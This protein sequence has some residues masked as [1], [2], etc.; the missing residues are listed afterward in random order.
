MTKSKVIEISTATGE[1]LSPFDKA[2]AAL[3]G[4]EGG[5]V[6]HP[7][8]KGGPTKFGIS[9]RSY[10]AFSIEEIKALT[11]DAAKEIYKRDFWDKLSLDKLTIYPLQ[12]E[13][14]EQSVNLGVE[15]AA[16]HAQMSIKLLGGTCH[17][18]GFLGPLSHEALDKVARA[19][20]L[21]LLK[22]LNGLQFSRYVNIVTGDSTQQA[23]FV[24]WLSRVDLK[25]V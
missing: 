18:D 19:N 8:D 7:A 1:K 11:L 3:I 21:A 24:G 22:V 6:D 15:R 25:L 13:L 4:V 9:R 5:Y 23:F 10:P 16:T 20:Y 17:V 2:F 12:L 14:F